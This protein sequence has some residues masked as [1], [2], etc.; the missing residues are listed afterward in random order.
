MSI[1]ELIKT[2]QHKSITMESDLA[3]RKIPTDFDPRHLCQAK[4]ITVLS[5][6]LLQDLCKKLCVSLVLLLLPLAFLFCFEEG[7]CLTFAF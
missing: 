4:S 3:I 2:M 5:M 6:W 1:R 7:I